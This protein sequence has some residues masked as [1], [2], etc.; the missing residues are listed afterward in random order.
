MIIKSYE[1]QNNKLGIILCDPNNDN[2]CKLV[3]QWT[4]K[5]ELIQKTFINKE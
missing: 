4:S 2:K 5:E 1:I 3:T